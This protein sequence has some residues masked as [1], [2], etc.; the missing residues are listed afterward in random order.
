MTG[1]GRIFTIAAGTLAMVVSSTAAGAAEAPPKATKAERVAEHFLDAYGKFD[2][3]R[4]LKYLSEDGV[5]TGSGTTGIPW[6][7]RDEFRKEVAMAK[8]RR[9][10][11]HV[12]GCDEQGTSGAGVAVQCAFEFDGFRSDEVGLGPYTDNTWDFVVR[13]GKISSAVA[14]W[15]YI[16]NG[17]SAE[18]WEPFRRWVA[19][20]HPEEMSTM[21]AADDGGFGIDKPSIG[22]WERR[23][24]EWVAAVKAGTA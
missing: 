15:A 12:I 9:I 11:Q 20:A 24:K 13:N 23:L 2:A 17:F 16:T 21:Y 18:R 10:K 14:T 4:A 22:L 5:V 7:S 19:S 8:A 6:G 3:T 1:R